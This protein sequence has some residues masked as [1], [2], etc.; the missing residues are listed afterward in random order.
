MWFLPRQLFSVFDFVKND[1]TQH[2]LSIELSQSQ[3]NDLDEKM[4]PAAGMEAAIRTSEVRFLLFTLRNHARSTFFF[5]RQASA[6]F[7]FVFMNS[8][9]FL[10]FCILPRYHIYT[11]IRTYYAY[12]AY[13]MKPVP[14]F[15]FR[16]DSAAAVKG[17]RQPAAFTVFIT[18]IL[19]TWT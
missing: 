19:W 7:F 4:Q 16:I 15:H 12:I 2:V 3:H 13:Y 8:V 11:Y 14:L 17:N 1:L 9:F 6:A 5:R 10:Y 18:A